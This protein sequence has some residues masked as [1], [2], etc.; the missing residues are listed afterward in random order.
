[1][2]AQSNGSLSDFYKVE[3]SLLGRDEILDG[4]EGSSLDI[5]NSLKKRS[6]VY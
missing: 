2:Q 3:I 4:C 6:D 1:M 5:L